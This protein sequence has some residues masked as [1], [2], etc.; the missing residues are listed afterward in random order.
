MVYVRNISDELLNIN[1]Q[2]SKMQIGK[3]ATKHSYEYQ[4]A[5]GRTESIIGHK[6]ITID[7][8]NSISN[9]T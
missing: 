4:T 1:Y 8:L 9:Y 3:K 2:I 7:D 5:T 6:T